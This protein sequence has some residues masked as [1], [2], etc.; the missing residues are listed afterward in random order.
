MHIPIFIFKPDDSVPEKNNN[1]KQCVK[2]YTKVSYDNH[3]GVY[4]ILCRSEN[5]VYIGQSINVPNRIKSHKSA[6]KRGSYSN[7]TKGLQKMQ[8]DY[9]KYGVEDFVFTQIAE[10]ESGDL[11]QLETESI[12]QYLD[13]D[14]EIY[15][16][17]VNTKLSGIFC[18]PQF[19]DVINRTIKLLDESKLSLSEFEAAIDKMENPWY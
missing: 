14:F 5:T 13:N 1:N 2:Q 8:S 11:Y 17:F 10:C 6:L 9:N 16:Y 18:P 4:C 12:K 3:I 19:R 15:N 7:N